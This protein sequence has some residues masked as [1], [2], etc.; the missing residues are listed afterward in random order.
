M[1][2][3]KS[4]SILHL[5]LSCAE[6]LEHLEQ[7]HPTLHLLC[8][9]SWVQ[10]WECLPAQPKRRV[11]PGSQVFSCQ[12]GKCSVPQQVKDAFHRVLMQLFH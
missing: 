3:Q 2:I 9:L 12:E 1:L 10:S 6:V 4:F 11:T 5:M 8:F 7:L